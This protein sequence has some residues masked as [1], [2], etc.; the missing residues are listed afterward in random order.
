MRIHVMSKSF[1]YLLLLLLLMMSIKY[2][3]NRQIFIAMTPCILSHQRSVII[4]VT[5]S[6][7][8]CERCSVKVARPG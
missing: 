1:I 3:V 4:I 7:T 6:G 8:E 5:Q 2:T